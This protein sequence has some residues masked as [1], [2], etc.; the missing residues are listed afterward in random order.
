MRTSI[1]SEGGSGAN[2]FSTRRAR[3]LLLAIVAGLATAATMLTIPA[4]SRADSSSSLTVIGTSDVSDSQLMQSVIEPAFNAAYPAYAPMSYVGTG[5]GQ[6]IANAEAGT[7]GASVLIVHAA[8]LENQ[9]V[10][11]G[12]SYPTGTY[13]NAL[14]TNK[15]VFAGS[16]ADPAGIGTDD[17]GNIVQAFVD[18]A[19]SGI[20][21]NSY[22]VSRG[23]T[24]GTSVEEHAIWALADAD[25]H[26]SLPSGL[27]LCTINA[28]SGGGEA[29]I[30]AGNGV[31]ADGQA[32]PNSGAVPGGALEP[33]WYVVTGLTQ[34]PNVEAANN[35]TYGGGDNCYVLTDDGTYA[36]LQNQNEIPDL[37]IVTSNNSGA[38][39]IGGQYLLINYFHGYIINPNK[40]NETVNLPAAQD[41]INLITSPSLQTQ[42]AAYLSSTT[43]ARTFG[44]PY[45]ATAAPTIAASV[46]PAV[47]KAGAK[48]TITGTV[49]NDEVGYPALSG[50]KV[51]V[52]EVSPTQLS[53]IAVG[54][55][56]AKG[57]FN[58]TF[59][60]SATG[61]YDVTTG[62][63]T[64]IEIKTLKPPFGDLFVPGTSNNVSVTVKASKG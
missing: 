6:A 11:Q 18:V 40:P 4:L 54:K 35:C 56:N 64:Q 59:E 25:L 47:V 26:P 37:G 24:P 9:F 33:A 14:F 30:A 53:K 44:V 21:G 16:P 20:Q 7:S 2:A 61:M 42:I 15:F 32:C 31:T 60:P 63:I 62:T 5:T 45:T 27:L 52:N 55:T 48:K 28:A 3:S 23:G 13:G 38:G 39:A 57:K 29:P 41:F 19:A 51:Y 36:Y 50:V 43:F 17:S 46:T 8:S 1:I 12:Y 49:T 10:S 34:G 22:F 58:F